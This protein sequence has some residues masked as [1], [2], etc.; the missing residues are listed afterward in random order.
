[1]VVRVVCVDDVVDNGI[2]VCQAC[3]RGH[4]PKPSEG[5]DDGMSGEEDGDEV[6][7]F[8]GEIVV[9]GVGECE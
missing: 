6:C 2:D 9:G 4:G 1:M 3:L 7:R 5:V 8:E